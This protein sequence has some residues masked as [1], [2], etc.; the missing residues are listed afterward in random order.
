MEKRRS[1]QA[2]EDMDGLR[3]KEVQGHG[4]RLT[5]TSRHPVEM[6]GVFSTARLLRFHKMT[7]PGQEVVFHA[8]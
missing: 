7:A 2:L 1:K 8:L 4:Y 5:E 6:R 3:Q